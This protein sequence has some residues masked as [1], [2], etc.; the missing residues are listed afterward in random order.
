MGTCLI[1]RLNSRRPFYNLYFEKCHLDTLMQMGRWFG[2]DRVIKIDTH[3]YARNFI[4]SLL[5]N[6][7]CNRRTSTRAWTMEAVNKTPL[8][9]SLK[10][11]NSDT[12]ILIVARNKLQS[13]ET[14]SFSKDFSSSHKQAYILTKERCEK[15]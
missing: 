12:G 11:R 15:K 1:E 6:S 10:V 14:I 13:A 5:F 9:F 2:Y 3:I 8:D 7:Y 4:R